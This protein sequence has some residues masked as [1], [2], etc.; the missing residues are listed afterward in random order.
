MDIYVVYSATMNIGV[1]VS[2]W[3]IVLFGYMLRSWIDGSYSSSIFSLMRNLYAVSI[4]VVAIYIPTNSLGSWNSW[5]IIN[6]LENVLKYDR[7]ENMMVNFIFG[8][9]Y[10]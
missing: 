8:I 3:I 9:V 6:E 2:L 5:S 7:I 4:V 10:I 1:H